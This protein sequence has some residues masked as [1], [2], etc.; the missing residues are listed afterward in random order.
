M[1]LPNWPE[2]Q[3]FLAYL[4]K[5]KS[6]HQTVFDSD[7]AEQAGISHTTVSN[8]RHGKQ[9]PGLPVLTRIVKA[10]GEP[11]NRLLAAAGFVRDDQPD[12][13]QRL[14][15]ALQQLIDLYTAAPPARKTPCSSRF[16]S[17]VTRRSCR[18]GTSGT[19]HAT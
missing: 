14:P 12:P 9:R 5:L 6:R 13:F 7:P 19:T 18:H 3:G 17:C 11:E 8:W 1:P 16:R 2:Q 15:A 4:D 10:L